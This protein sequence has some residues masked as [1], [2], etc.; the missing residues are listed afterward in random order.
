ME[1][2]PQ[3]INQEKEEGEMDQIINIDNNINNENQN[4]ESN[5]NAPKI[6][7]PLSEEKYKFLK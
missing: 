2:S 4:P 3:S 6:E 7:K 5:M 1:E